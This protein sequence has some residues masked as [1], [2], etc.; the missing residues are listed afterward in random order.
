VGGDALLYSHSEARP[1]TAFTCRLSYRNFRAAAQA[2]VRGYDW[3]DASQGMHQGQ[4]GADFGPLSTLASC[5][6]TIDRRRFVS[7]EPSSTAA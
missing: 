3:G 7:V 6:E 5:C 2:Q 4:P 1:N